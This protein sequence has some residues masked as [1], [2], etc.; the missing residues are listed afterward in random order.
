MYRCDQSQRYRCEIEG[1]NAVR[2][3]TWWRMP[4]LSIAPVHG[5][6]SPRPQMWIARQIG[7]NNPPRDAEQ[8]QH[9]S[10]RFGSQWPTDTIGDDYGPVRSGRVSVSTV[11]FGDSAH[12]LF[13]SFRFPLSR[14]SFTVSI[15]SVLNLKHK[16]RAEQPVATTTRNMSLFLVVWPQLWFCSSTF[17]TLA[18]HFQ[19]ITKTQSQL[20]RFNCEPFNGRIHPSTSACRFNQG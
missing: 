11:R 8:V 2:T 6:A 12:R 14:L 4:C 1:K 9:T 16:R 15:L 13:L 3:E 18:D 7:C 10:K 20:T 19:S 17:L 5:V